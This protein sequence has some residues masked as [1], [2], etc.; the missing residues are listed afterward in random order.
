ME[1][2]LSYHQLGVRAAHVEAG[3]DAVTPLG[4]KSSDDGLRGER[5]EVRRLPCLQRRPNSIRLFCGITLLDA[6]VPKLSSS[7]AVS[8]VI[9]PVTPEMWNSRSPSSCTELNLHDTQTQTVDTE[10][11]LI[12]PRR[13][14]VR[15]S[16][17]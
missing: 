2:S 14:A 3:Q 4:A 5:T 10:R 9:F 16:P 13:V 15:L 1:G 6:A 7:E 11:T 8:V 12:Y 17:T